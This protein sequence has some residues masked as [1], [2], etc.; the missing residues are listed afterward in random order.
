MRITLFNGFVI[1]VDDNENYTLNEIKGTSEVKDKDGNMIEKENIKNYG[2]HSSLNNALNKYLRVITTK[3]S[4]T[5]TI[6]QYIERYEKAKIEV[7]QEIKKEKVN[8]SM[9]KM[10]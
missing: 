10:W 2:Y 3:N 7:L 1:D 8:E 9:Y 4:D 5:I 6:K